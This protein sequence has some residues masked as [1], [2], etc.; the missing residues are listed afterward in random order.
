MCASRWMEALESRLVMSAPVAQ[1]TSVSVG[2]TDM[3]VVVKYTSP[4]GIDLATIGAAD[5]RMTAA[6]KTTGVTPL[7]AF[8]ALATLKAAPT[9]AADG[10]VTARYVF[11]ARTGAWDWA[12]NGSYTVTL[13][14]QQVRSKGGAWNSAADL[15]K[16]SLW[17][18]TP[19]AEV[20]S[21][22]L[23]N[24]SQWLIGVKYTDDKGLDRASIGTG[25]LKVTGPGGTVSIAR[26]AYTS[27]SG[28]SVTAYY[29]AK[30]AQVSGSWMDRGSYTFT[31]MGGEV[32]DTA[33]NLLPSYT[34]TTSAYASDRPAAVLASSSFSNSAWTVKVRYH[35]ELGI[36]LASVGDGDIQYSGAKGTVLATLVGTPTVGSD[37][38]VLATYS[39]AAP[40]GGWDSSAGAYTLSSRASQVFEKVIRVGQNSRLSV[41]S[42]YFVHGGFM[43]TGPAEAP[44]GATS[45][46]VVSSSKTSTKT[47]EVTVRYTDADGL[48]DASLTSGSALLMYG[49]KLSSGGG[50]FKSSLTVLSASRESATSWVVSYRMT[51]AATLASGS[52]YLRTNSFQVKD[53]V[54][55]LMPSVEVMALAL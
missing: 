50:A 43:A 7:P 45:A 19:H 13:Q 31:S 17:F 28:T 26:L 51:S 9:V 10:S 22:T 49:P 54:G 30:V 8:S 3:V 36:D 12:D 38:S 4:A 41:L 5:L 44:Y 53:A 16:Y 40:V 55:N 46:A 11:A 42:G 2:A 48:D 6:A 27:G 23:G 25:D 21:A 37:G 1:I 39:M 24:M 47:W 18:S 14:A 15:K 32:R 33:G 34:L 20:V 52:Y 29:Y 35:A